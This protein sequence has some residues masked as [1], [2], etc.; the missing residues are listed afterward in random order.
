M[1]RNELRQTLVAGIDKIL[2]SR[3]ASWS[4]SDVHDGHGLSASGRSAVRP[5][6][7]PGRTSSALRG[8]IML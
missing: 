3:V 5:V 2:G 1:D 4:M 6:V 8:N 7:G